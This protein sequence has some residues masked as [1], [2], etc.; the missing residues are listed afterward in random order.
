M[1]TKQSEWTMRGR[2]EISRK[3]VAKGVWKLRDGSGYFVRARVVSGKTGKQVGIERSLSVAKVSEALAWLEQEMATV[4]GGAALASTKIPTFGNYALLLMERKKERGELASAASL[5]RWSDTIRLHLLKFFGDMYLDQIT[6]RDVRAWTDAITNLIKPPR[7]WEPPK[8]RPGRTMLLKVGTR[9]T[10][11]SL[12]TVARVVM[13]RAPHTVLVAREKGSK[14]VRIA[15]SAITQVLPAQPPPY[16]PEPYDAETK[17]GWI[18]IFKTIVRAGLEEFEIE[19]TPLVGLV[20]FAERVDEEE[21]DEDD[22]DSCALTPE[23]T[24]RFLDYMRM[25]YPQWFAM[26]MLGFYTGARPSSLRPLR[27][28]GPNADI[29]WETGRVLIRRSHSRGREIMIGTKTS[30]R[31]GKRATP[32]YLDEPML[33][34]LR[35]HERTLTETREQRESELMFS[36]KDGKV[37]SL[38]AL[39]GV[40]AKVLAALGITKNFTPKG[41][42]RTYTD[43]ARQGNVDPLVRRRISGHETDAMVDHYSSVRAAEQHAAFASIRTLIGGGKVGDKVGDEIV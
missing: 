33:K 7:K 10:Y 27:R 38:S 3:P 9:I 1:A 16:V 20:M 42:R 18:R 40:F 11:G 21:G 23:E 31:T 34:V 35:Q 43:L 36:S 22:D 17:N 4:R 32:L 37:R 19:R 6:R 12:N 41:M 14:Q 24:R 15:R 8:P 28:S 26:T 39:R 30:K 25:S 13:A 5:E 29:N 2:V